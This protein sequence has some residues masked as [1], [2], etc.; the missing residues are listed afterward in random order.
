MPAPAG[1]LELGA[2]LDPLTRARTAEPVH[3]RA[4]DLTTHGVI[5]GMT[6]SGKTG[7]GIVAIE[8]ALLQGI[9]V[10]A[11][12]PK[13]DL[14]NLL[15]TF[16]DL[17]P[18]QFEPW[19]NPGDAERKGVTVAAY[20]EQQAA[21]WRD[22]LQGWG[23][24]AERVRAL[25]ERADLVIYTPGSSAGVGLDVVGSLT[26]PAEGVDAETRADEIEG[27]VT[28]LL[29]LVGIEA[30][31]IASREHILLSSLIGHAWAQGR[32]LDLPGLVLQVTDPPLRKLGVFELDTFFPARDR[33]AL[34]MRLNGLIAAPS[35]ATWT[36]GPPL[37][38]ATLLRAP[39]GRPRC[40]IVSLAHLSDAERQFVVTLLLSR[41]ITWMRGLPGTSDLR[42]L[43]YMDEVFGY[44]PP[45]AAPPS[46]KPI[47]TLLKQA[48]AF[49]VGMVLSTQ[50]PVDVDYKALSNAGTWMIGRLQTERDKARLM[51]GLSSAAGGVDTNALGE[52][53]SGL[54][55]REFVL[56]TTRGAPPAL[57]TTR[58]AL[59]YLR[60]PLT[61]DQIQR[62]MAD[63]MEK[64]PAHPGVDA[65]GSSGAAPS[66][67]ASA[68]TSPPLADDALL[69]PPTV[70]A[71]VPVYHLDPAA[72]WSG[73]I[74]ANP[75]SDR[76]EAAVVARVQL[77][78][79]ETKADLR[80]QE[81]WEAVFFPLERV[82]DPTSGLQVDY[83]A[84][85]LRERP[86]RAG[87][88]VAP[89]APLDERRWFS[90]LEAAL[91][92]HLYRNRQVEVLVNREL[93]LY[94]RVDEDRAAF[95]ARCHDA[96]ETEEDAEAARIRDRMEKRM[97]SV[98][99]AL[100]K[101]EDRVEEL[102]ETARHRR[103]QEV[104][105]GVGS[106]L[107]AFLGGKRTTR[108]IATELRRAS[109]RRGSTAGAVQ[110][111]DSAVNRAQENESEL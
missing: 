82:V 10:L 56:H 29:G 72:P 86:V 4:S 77:L 16:P 55:A 28:S 102:Q 6:G 51:D 34:A 49:G 62:L 3:V 44:V 18:A 70:A 75:T 27:F 83:D 98:R 30:D 99:Q 45:T 39:D 11:I 84:R 57:F 65:V 92:E 5:V 26:P 23:L 64:A 67:G 19:V 8:E 9:P 81:E 87:S 105:S 107:S 76:Y 22:G 104:L 36:Q 14:G 7:L 79:D 53:I 97:D 96:A 58:W 85:D 80:H 40:A 31:P 42:A 73:S 21:K 32:A 48:R 1:H 109:S 38:P 33:M 88:Y 69:A 74:G 50:N 24:G 78:F 17:S 47:L 106:V 91:K 13:G 93:K 110:R 90:E 108:S 41:T 52:T 66:S 111:L 60:G 2:R 63:R 54:G 101:A 95:A 37:D 94:S 59:S 20:A 71:G 12:D 89:E 15:L 100:A 46:K 25:R 68:P 35:F 43:V 103:S 61:R